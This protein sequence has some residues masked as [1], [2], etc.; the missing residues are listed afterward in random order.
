[1]TL[2][3]GAVCDLLRAQAKDRCQAVA[4]AGAATVYQSGSAAGI[5]RLVL[6]IDTGDRVVV[7][8]PVDVVA[9]QLASATP[10]LRQVAIDGQPGVV[11]DVVATWKPGAPTAHRQSVVGCTQ[12]G[13]LWKCAQVDV[14]A[15]DARVGADGT[16]TTSCGASAPLSIE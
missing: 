6:A 4:Q 2:A 16:I 8:P 11:L 12:R 13:A 9:E 1:M 7:S 10:T 14:G 15:C 3:D 5:R